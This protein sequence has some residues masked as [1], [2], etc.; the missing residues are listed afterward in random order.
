[1]QESF[2][3]CV[4][5]FLALYGICCLLR[6]LTL[7]VLLPRETLHTFSLAYLRKDTQNTEQI[8]RYFQ[9]K[10]EKGDL[11]MLVDNGVSEDE[12][13]VLHRLCANS[14]NIRLISDENFVEENCNQ[15][16]NAV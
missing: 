11:L 2:A 3:F 8:V 9:A 4:V 7:L 15:N 1:M 14:R 6:R 16:E 12:K 10:A 13:Q 5:L